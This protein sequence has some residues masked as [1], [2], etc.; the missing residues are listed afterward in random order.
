[1]SKSGNAKRG[2]VPQE[3]TDNGYTVG[4]RSLFQGNSEILT[5]LEDWRSQARAAQSE[6]RHEMHL[7]EEFYDGNQWDPE[8]KHYL[9]TVRGQPALTF[10]IIAPMIR[11]VTGT[12][13][14]TRVDF[15]ILARK[16]DLQQAAEA[17]TE[18]MKYV[19]DVNKSAFA[20]SKAFESV[21]K[22]GVGWLEGGVKSEPG[23]EPIYE[24]SE[25]WRNIWYDHLSTEDDYSDARF[26]FRERSA[27]L[28]VAQAMFPKHHDSL[29]LVADQMDGMKL[30]DDD[31]Y[32]INP[33]LYPESRMTG[34]RMGTVDEAWQSANRRPRVRLIECW[35]RL[36]MEVEVMHGDGGWNG[37]IFNPEDEVHSWAKDS[38]MATTFKAVKQV[39]HHCIFVE[40]LILQDPQRLPYHH[41]RY[42]LTPIWGFRR[43]KDNAPYG[44]VRG[45]RD[46]Q[47]DLNKRRSKALHI[48]STKQVIMDKGAVDDIDVLAEEIAA[49]D[50]I[51]EKN[52][53][54]ELRIDQNQS[55]A[56]QHVA[57]MHED[58]MFV[59]SIS[60]VTDENMG[61]AT[62]A[63]SGRAIE[64][65]QNQGVATTMDLFDH[66]RFALQIHGE[67]RLSLVEQYHDDEKEIR[68][69][70]V[71]GKP[72]F[73]TINGET[74][75]VSNQA[76]FIV[77]DQAFQETTRKAMFAMMMEMVQKLPGDLA[78]QV[79][80]L[81]FDMSDVPQR[82]EWVTRIRKMNG[83]K[84]P[85]VEPTPE[86]EEADQAAEQYQQET[87][88]RLEQ[89]E[90]G[91]KE[92]EARLKNS[93]ADNEQMKSMLTKLEGML[94]SLQVAGVI[95]TDPEAAAVADEVMEDAARI[96]PE[97]PA[98]EEAPVEQ[99]LA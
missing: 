49:P 18:L 10:N 12:E 19:S 52:P 28:M 1:M 7:D 70:E 74:D 15:R 64:A 44:L 48:L 84:D 6:N 78:I 97:V 45:V 55:L 67:K 90:I 95:V 76:D 8:D 13:K 29:R 51:I 77:D 38:G 25:S 33:H 2:T 36:P 41:N 79:L 61:R 57:L 32:F 20:V 81:V 94:N 17:K 92:G 4:G 11:W 54:M 23:G 69:S 3:L 71:R 63:T 85:D 58:A 59:Q 93:Q 72:K 30:T 47:E 43:G 98:E 62:N 40:G 24:R 26:L 16:K 73:Q 91:L 60:G 66:L 35:F 56:Q 5:M 87:A 42:P 46:P 82:E 53:G 14:R 80:D 68:I 21:V 9:E 39:M 75:I 37:A 86:E 88:M 83:H 34:A 31:E 27:D 89:A 50:G 96:Q 65:R 99:P 22:V